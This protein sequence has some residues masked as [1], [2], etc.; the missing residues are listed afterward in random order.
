MSQAERADVL[1][2]LARV[3]VG[4]VGPVSRGGRGKRNPVKEKAMKASAA[5]PKEQQVSERTIKRAIAKAEGRKP[6][7][8]PLSEPKPEQPL[9]T[10]VHQ[11]RGHL[12]EA[13]NAEARAIKL[14]HQAGQKLLRLRQR[15]ALSEE[16]WWDRLSG[17]EYCHFAAVRKLKDCS[18]RLIPVAKQ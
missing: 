12:Y 3:E 11:I 1:V 15:M 4:H 8:K 2:R 18:K 16:E 5:L 17:R 9:S 13:K 14:R 7:P 10:V 6:E